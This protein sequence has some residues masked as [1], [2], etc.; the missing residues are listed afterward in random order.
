MAQQKLYTEEQV[1]EVVRL[2]LEYAE[3]SVVWSKGY[4]QKLADKILQSLQPIELPTYNDI[5]NEADEK[6]K[7]FYDNSG[8]DIF[9]EGCAWVVVSLREKY[10]QILNQIK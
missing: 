4:P 7:Y 10:E 6:P 2:S 8:R 5:I 1:R 9:I 3:T